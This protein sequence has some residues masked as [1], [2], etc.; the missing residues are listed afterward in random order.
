VAKGH[1]CC[2]P[3]TR[4]DEIASLATHKQRHK[5]LAPLTPKGI[6]FARNKQLAQ[7]TEEM[8]AMLAR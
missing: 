3:P 7:C 6:R 4:R 5:K 8:L 2:P 1:A